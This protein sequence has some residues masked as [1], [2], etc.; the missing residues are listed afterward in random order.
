MKNIPAYL[1]LYLFLLSACGPA[2]PAATPVT[3][4]LQYT[5]ATRPWL[6]DLYT[7]AGRNVVD[8]QLVSADTMDVNTA[9]F[10]MRIGETPHMSSPTYQIGT[11]SLEVIA[12]PQ[13]LLKQL[14]LEQVQE[15][16]TGR[17]QNWKDLQGPDAPVEV[18]VFA[19]GE[20]VEQLFEQTGLGGS[21]VTSLARL[22]VSPDEMAEAIAGDANAVGILTKAWKAEG[23]S[24]LLTIA[25]E[26]VLVSTPVEPQ[27]AVL[28]IIN[29]LQK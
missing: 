5:A 17:I 15:I 11:D 22:A 28:Q 14:N 8:A 12:N 26:P 4:R 29:C 10:T 3:L 23:V 19:S 18:W 16:F 20:D 9:D 13:N 21:P 24:N 6:A 27:G 25:T 1:F 7:C 2:T